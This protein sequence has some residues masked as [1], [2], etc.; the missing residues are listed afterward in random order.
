MTK[1]TKPG[2]AALNSLYAKQLTGAVGELLERGVIHIDQ[3]KALATQDATGE[4]LAIEHALAS[5]G[6][7]PELISLVQ[8][9]LLFTGY[10][11]KLVA[12]DRVPSWMEF[13]LSMDRV[14]AVT[15]LPQ[16]QSSR[17]GDTL[18]FVNEWIRNSFANTVVG[19]ELPQDSNT[20]AP[21]LQISDLENK[22]ESELVVSD[23]R[24]SINAAIM[25]LG[26][27]LTATTTASIQQI[28]SIHDDFFTAISRMSAIDLRSANFLH[29]RRSEALRH[30][31]RVTLTALLLSVYAHAVFY[32]IDLP[33]E[34]ESVLSGIE[35]KVNNLTD[36]EKLLNSLLDGTFGYYVLH[37]NK[38]NS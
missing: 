16:T 21:P 30:Q 15:E 35:S 12:E 26:N 31:A 5:S 32:D 37:Y 4:L 20:F 8:N 18:S 23:L 25:S 33:T 11:T 3:A 34:I 17:I 36:T 27:G 2:G 24:D 10:M 22:E 1:S 13:S 7:A 38:V 28:E 19:K 14:T 6:L 29:E 9:S